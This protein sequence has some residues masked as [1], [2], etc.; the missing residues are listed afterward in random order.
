M[1]SSS[2]TSTT[3]LNSPLTL[4]VEPLNEDPTT[5][6]NEV[7][8]LHNSFSLHP[9]LTSTH[10]L[11]SNDLKLSDPT[12]PSIHPSYSSNNLFSLF[13]KN[14]AALITPLSTNDTLSFFSAN[15]NNTNTN[16]PTPLLTPVS[17]PTPVS[18]TSNMSMSNIHS[19]T[20]LLDS[21]VNPSDLPSSNQ[22][23]LSTTKPIVES[24]PHPTTIEPKT[25]EPET[26]QNLNT[27]SYN[28]LCSKTPL[29]YSF[30]QLYKIHLVTHLPIS[31]VLVKQSLTNPQFHQN[32]YPQDAHEFLL[33]IIG[34]LEDELLELARHYLC[35]GSYDEENEDYQCLKD[36]DEI[37]QVINEIIHSLITSKEQRIYPSSFYSK[38]LDLIKTLPTY[39]CFS[40]IVQNTIDCNQCHHKKSTYETYSN[41]SLNIDE[42]FLQQSNTEPLN[43]HCSYY[44]NY[45]TKSTT[46]SESATIT[47]PPTTVPTQTMN[48]SLNGTVP[49]SNPIEMNDNSTTPVSYDYQSLSSL[50]TS[51]PTISRDD[52]Y[53]S[54]VHEVYDRF[55]TKP[56][57]EELSKDPS[58]IISMHINDPFWIESDSTLGNHN[59]SR[60]K[61]KKEHDILLDFIIKS[62]FLP[63][64]FCSFLSLFS[65]L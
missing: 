54:F 22:Q 30:L 41:F 13:T 58:E 23:H 29:F 57:S 15:N 40:T 1:F 33:Y 3:L 59:N 32:H 45:M 20:P 8:S 43:I 46:H 16:T 52:Y 44:S 36:K 38:L 65:S 26:N 31:P 49:L 6:L 48:G 53:N 28:T 27:T 60:R 2:L 21:I 35:I 51:N 61:K 19:S 4:D 62:A 37:H 18:T 42:V 50:F 25:D 47:T 11:D 64:V 24:S 7:E 34:Q 63:E 10:H 55:S 14:D 9:P 17:T 56:P 39:K 12:T 5:P